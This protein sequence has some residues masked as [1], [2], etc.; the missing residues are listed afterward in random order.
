[1]DLFGGQLADAGIEHFRLAQQ[2]KHGLALQGAELKGLRPAGLDGL[3]GAGI[4]FGP[5]PTRS[6]SYPLPNLASYAGSIIQF[7]GMDFMRTLANPGIL[8]CLQKDSTGGQMILQPFGHCPG[9]P[10]GRFQNHRLANGLQT[11]RHQPG[12]R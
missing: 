12:N 10:T 3:R 9:L 6:L 7:L 1:M 8:T 5:E 11:L 4:S 2:R